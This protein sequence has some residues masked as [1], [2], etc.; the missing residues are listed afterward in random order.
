ME[1]PAGNMRLSI[2]SPPELAQNLEIM[3]NTR[4]SHI[5]HIVLTGAFA[6]TVL[7]LGP[8]ASAQNINW[9][10]PA[11]ITG[12]STLSTSGVYFDAF[13]PEAPASLTAD[14]VLFN[15]DVSVSPSGGGDGIISYLWTTTGNSRYDYS[16]YTLGTAGFNAVMNAGG[17][18]E[19]GVASGT[20]TIGGLTTGDIYSVQDFEYAD[21]ANGVTTFSG[22][23]PT[24]ISSGGADGEFV[25]GI[26]TA[27][28]AD[29]TFG[30]TGDSGTGFTVLGSISVFDITAVPEPSTASLLAGGLVFFSVMCLVR[31]RKLEH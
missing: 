11:A 28:S 19:N 26:F 29:E 8:V 15:D 13:V 27:T 6:A 17:A 21:G 30:F 23:T 4:I 16:T 7:T 31:R 5:A 20:V 3:K 2:A 18:Y 24:T 22:S 25:T 14:G 10:S 9:S 1:F 12:D